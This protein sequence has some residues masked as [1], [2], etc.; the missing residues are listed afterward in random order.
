MTGKV[1][2][3][4]SVV[5]KGIDS[6]RKWLQEN[7]ARINKAYNSALRI[8][9]FRLR[10]LLIKEIRQGK[11][12]GKR[13][14]SLSYIS[15]RANRQTWIRGGT[16]RKTDPNR[17]PLARLAQGVRYDANPRPPYA[18]AVGWV[19]PMTWREAD[20]R[21]G[22][23]GSLV[24]Q[25]SNQLRYNAFMNPLKRGMKRSGISSKKWRSLAKSHQE[26]FT[27]KIT[28]KQREWLANRGAKLLEAGGYESSEDL[29]TP[30]FLQ[31]STRY[32][33]TPARPIM[34]PFWQAYEDDARRNIK[35]NFSMKMKGKRI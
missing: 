11:P 9:G 14:K 20:L 29:D 2:N 12:G 16:T 4:N 31:K 10:N 25:H 26:G 8:E 28:K 13:L 32:F 23:T 15:R 33:H 30:F 1:L 24:N 3:K 34:E 21:K 5:V 19:G 22:Y 35:R 6:T 18:V 7:D 17:K 27:R